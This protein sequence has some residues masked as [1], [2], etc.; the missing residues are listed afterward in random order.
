[1]LTPQLIGRRVR[2]TAW[3]DHAPLVAARRRPTTPG[4]GPE[5]TVTH[6]D[7]LT[8]RVSV[9]LEGMDRTFVLPCGDVEV[10]PEG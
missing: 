4:D 1:M 5:G 6:L 2:V 9:R 3:Y 7:E 10:L 8:G